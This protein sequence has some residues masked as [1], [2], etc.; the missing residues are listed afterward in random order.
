M[1]RLYRY[2]E[3]ILPS[4]IVLG[5]F[6]IQLGTFFFVDSLWAVAGVML[7]LL[8]C[9]AMPGLISHNHH[10]V[11]T[12]RSA[13]LNRPYELILFMETGVLP[14]AWTLHHNLGHHK[15]YLDQEKDPAN[16][17]LA[18]GRVMSRVRYDVVGALRIYPEIVRIGRQY[19]ELFRR[20][21]VWSAIA[22][23]LLGVFVLLD[24]VKALVLFIA[25]IPV[26][27]LG[28]MDNTYMQHSDLDTSSELTASRNTTSRL[29]NFI[30]WNLGY[31]TA[32]H[33]KPNVHWSRLP[34]LYARLEWQIPDG[35]KCDSVLLSD[36][37]YRHSRDAAVPDAIC[38]LRPAAPAR[39]TPAQLRL[40][41]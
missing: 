21:K 38:Y 15:D 3:D 9:S 20:F 23:A 18:D 28:L 19:P 4:C 40:A 14:F 35:V 22:L 25:P 32:H 36:C 17:R 10:H 24:P 6:A 11:P 29:Y 5:I 27:Y 41:A 16:W 33:M 37:S 39:W 2:R 26:M 13:W 12:F 1:S 31:H 34:E 30:S 8:A 7:A